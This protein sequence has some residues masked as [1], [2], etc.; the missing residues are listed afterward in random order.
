MAKLEE[1]EKSQKLKESNAITQEKKKIKLLN[2][3]IFF[4]LAGI[5]LIITIINI[6]MTNSCDKKFRTAMNNRSTKEYLNA[7]SQYEIYGD[8]TK[9]NE[10]NEESKK[11]YWLE[12]KTKI[13]TV[14]SIVTSGI[15]VVILGTGIVLKVK[16]KRKN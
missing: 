2:S 14:V 10:Y 3:K 12:D 9:L 16:E 13:L 11:I 5:F 1:L 4:M 8:K 6:C 7:L 15:T